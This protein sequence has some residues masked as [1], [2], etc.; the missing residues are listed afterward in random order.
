MGASDDG[1]IEITDQRT[2][3]QRRSAKAE[4]SGRTIMTRSKDKDRQVLDTK[5]LPEEW[6]ELLREQIAK[7][8]EALVNRS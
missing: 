5:D 4:K 3:R 2:R 8:A 1:F 7:D 6:Q